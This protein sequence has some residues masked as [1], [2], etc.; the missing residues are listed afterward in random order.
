MIK[1]AHKPR[2]CAQMHRD[3]WTTMASEQVSLGG[4]R[5]FRC[6][7]L[8]LWVDSSCIFVVLK[9]LANGLAVAPG[10]EASCCLEYHNC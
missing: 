2:A 1:T 3:T 6:G 7:L 5:S 8:V 4:M 9:L 10:I